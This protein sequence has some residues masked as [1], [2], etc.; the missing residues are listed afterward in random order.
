MIYFNKLINLMIK[1]ER[2][3]RENWKR[4]LKEELGGFL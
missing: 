2:E 4:K 1:I 3:C